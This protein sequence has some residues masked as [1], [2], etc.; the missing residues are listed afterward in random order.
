MAKFWRVLGFILLALNVAAALF[1]MFRVGMLIGVLSG[2]S[3]ILSGALLIT[4]GGLIERIDR[5][6][7]KKDEE[8]RLARGG[9]TL[10]KPCK[11]CPHCGREHDADYSSCPHCGHRG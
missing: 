1:L 4:V 6:E 5:L 8:S 2:L 9:Y 7:Y 11:V 10:T 3:G